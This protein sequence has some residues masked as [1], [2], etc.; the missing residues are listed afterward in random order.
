V[1]LCGQSI[2]AAATLA[3]QAYRN[4]TID[5]RVIPLCENFL[6]VGE[7]G[8]RKTAVDHEALRPHRAYEKQLH[9]KYEAGMRDYENDM[10]AYKKAREEALKKAK[11]RGEKKNALDALGPAPEEP[12]L[13]NFL[14][15]EPTYEGLVKLLLR[16]QLGVGLFAHE[17]GRMIGGY[18]MSED[19]QLKTAAGLSEFWDGNRVS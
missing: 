5:G 7:S 13:P 16:G 1:A 6:T 10:A 11:T 19:Q 12:L 18:G 17:G 9:E 14:I 4:V 2:L 15:E 8:E 3:V